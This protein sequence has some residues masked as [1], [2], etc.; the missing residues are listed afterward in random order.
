MSKLEFCT[1]KQPKLF[2]KFILNK[3]KRG[4]KPTKDS[5]SHAV[6][7]HAR[8]VK[9]YRPGHK[10][11]NFFLYKTQKPFSFMSMSF[12]INKPLNQLHFAKW[13]FGNIKLIRCVFVSNINQIV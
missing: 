2:E 3:E 13:I 10:S 12:T 5:S 11:K 4:K 7:I 9:I 8:T 1:F 6:K